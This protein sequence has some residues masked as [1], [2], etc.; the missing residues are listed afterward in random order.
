MKT[1]IRTTVVLSLV[2]A[3]IFYIKT[4]DGYASKRAGCQAFIYIAN[5]STFECRIQI[6]GISQT[7]TMLPS[8]VKTFSTELLNDKSK[9]VKVKIF[10]ENPDYLESMSYVMITH[11]LQCGLTDTMYI[12]H[13]K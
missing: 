4:N 5:N 12:A 1:L 11:E 13:T 8:K 2:V 3:A 7:G 9:R 6:D 10:Y